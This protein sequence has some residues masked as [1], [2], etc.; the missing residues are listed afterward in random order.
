MIHCRKALELDPN[1]AMAHTYLG[2]AYM[3]KRMYPEAIEEL[4][5]AVVLS[6]R[7]PEI[8]AILGYAYADAGNHKEAEKV[9]RE[10]TESPG[11]RYKPS[12][13]IARIYSVLGRNDEAFSD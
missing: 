13:S 3:Q 6:E 5:R 10:L 12:Y 8:V 1:Y 11:S 9:L 2:Q 4:Q 7:N